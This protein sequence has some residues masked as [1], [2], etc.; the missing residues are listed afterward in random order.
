MEERIGALTDADHSEFKRRPRP[1]FKAWDREDR[2]IDKAIAAEARGRRKAS[3]SASASAEA[4]GV[5]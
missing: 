4:G 5:S 3:V 1:F 2:L